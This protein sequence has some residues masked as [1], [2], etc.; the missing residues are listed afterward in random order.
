MPSTIAGQSQSS[1]RM[2]IESA[3]GIKQ[4]L[5]HHPEMCGS[6]AK[7][8][9]MPSDTTHSQKSTGL[10]TSQSSSTLQVSHPQGSD[11]CSAQDVLVA[12]KK[13]TPLEQQFIDIKAEYPDAVLFVE[14]GYKYRFFGEDA[15]IASKELKIGCFLVH[16]FVTA[17][18]PVHRLHVHLRRYYVHSNNMVASYV[19]F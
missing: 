15:E 4:N 17:S 18:I 6:K 14:C 11:G 1:P 2:D 13:Y 12:T 3:C 9:D 8:T 16:N 19:M 5:K 10:S 7:V